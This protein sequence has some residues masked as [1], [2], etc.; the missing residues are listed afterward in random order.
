MI[1]A[2]GLVYQR[3][4]DLI[5]AAREGNPHIEQFE[6]SVFDGHYVTGDVNDGY[7]SRLHEER[8]DGAKQAREQL[9]LGLEVL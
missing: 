3:L 5:A 4:E 2:D 6:C 9:R 8:T 7:L 1:G